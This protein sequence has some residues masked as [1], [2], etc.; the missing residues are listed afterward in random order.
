MNPRIKLINETLRIDKLTIELSRVDNV[1]ELYDSIIEKGEEHEDFKDE[2]IP[3]WAEL[4][5][6]AIALSHFLIEKEKIK[7]GEVVLELGCGLGLAGLVAGKL[8][9]E[10]VFTDFIPDALELAK[11]NWDKNTFQAKASFEIL[12]WRNPN[13]HVRPDWIIAADVAYEERVLKP[14]I[15]T[16]SFYKK[17]LPKILITEP[18]RQMGALFLE[19]LKKEGFHIKENSMDITYR[20]IRTK[21][22]IWELTWQ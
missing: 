14:L 15:Q 11:T 9:A 2:K 10:V 6:S 8:G 1:D 3:Y 13:L 5:P 17:D 21:V 16:F 12:D 4:W 22:G 19:L 20:T 7:P 18:G